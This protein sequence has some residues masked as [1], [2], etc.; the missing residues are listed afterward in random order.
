ML[1]LVSRTWGIEV[2]FC[3]PRIGNSLGVTH[4]IFNK[5]FWNLSEASMLSA[6]LGPCP[7]RGAQGKGT[8]CA[9]YGAPI[10]LGLYTE[11]PPER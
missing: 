1:K 11:W 3:L 10:L 4:C 9:N 8:V 6:R 5:R 7:L 2:S